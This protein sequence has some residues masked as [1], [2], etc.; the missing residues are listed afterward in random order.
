MPKE[1][2]T[3][4]IAAILIVTLLV[5]GLFIFINQQDDTPADTTENREGT[6]IKQDFYKDAPPPFVD[7]EEL[8]QMRNLWPDAFNLQKVDRE[9]VKREW[10]EFASIYPENVYIPSRFLPEQ[11]AEQKQKQREVLDQVSS[12]EIRLAS[13]R[14]AQRTSGDDKQRK[15]ESDPGQGDITPAEQQLYFTQKLKEL[16]SRQQLIEYALHQNKLDVDQI[17][18]AKADLAAIEKEI[19]N[20]NTAMAEIPAAE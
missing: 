19:Q 2:K 1:K 11:T 8:D 17:P 14:A 13:Q 20:L 5:I 7:E 4:F 12:I 16:E 9:E 3:L 18:T 6:E 10:K 15:T